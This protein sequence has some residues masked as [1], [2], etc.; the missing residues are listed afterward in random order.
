MRNVGQLFEQV[1]GRFCRRWFGQGLAGQDVLEGLQNDARRRG[2]E[3]RGGFE[4]G[5]AAGGSEERRFGGAGRGG[6]EEDQASRDE[7]G[8]GSQ[9]ARWQVE[10]LPPLEDPLPQETVCTR[11]IDERAIA[12]KVVYFTLIFGGLG[13]SLPLLIGESTGGKPLSRRQI[14]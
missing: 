9:P 10:N 5:E 14:S 1:F 8:A 12:K 7:G 3:R 4:H 13:E 6:A 11:A 2:G